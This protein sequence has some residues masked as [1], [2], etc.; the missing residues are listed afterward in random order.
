MPSRALK[1]VDPAALKAHLAALRE[2]HPDDPL[3]GEVERLGDAHQRLLRRMDKL[4]RISDG[5]QAQLKQVNASLQVASRT[6]PLTGLPNRRAML[7]ELR[8]ERLRAIRKHIP[9]AVLMTDVDRFKTVNDCCGHEAGDLLLRTL[10][11]V[12]RDALRAYDVCCRWGGDEFLVLLPSTDA[13]G[14][15]EVGEKLRRATEKLSASAG[16]RKIRL[17]LSV[18]VAVLEAEESIDDLLRQADQDMYAKK[19]AAHR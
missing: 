17:G 12:L 5:F 18:G 19:R 16:H 2:A 11:Q 7:E 9:M 8:A 13:A 15:R 1:Y 6:D 3:L 4:T 14:A 10:A